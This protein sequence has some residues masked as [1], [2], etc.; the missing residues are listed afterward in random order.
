M[1]I[2]IR[3]CNLKVFFYINFFKKIYFYVIFV[4]MYFYIIFCMLSILEF[5][6]NMDSMIMGIFLL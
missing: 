1:F 3:L 4:L 6:E 5:G 2:K